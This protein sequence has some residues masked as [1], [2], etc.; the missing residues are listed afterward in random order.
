MLY[1]IRLVF[2]RRNNGKKDNIKEISKRKYGRKIQKEDFKKTDMI[3]LQN[4]VRSKF[5][6]NKNMIKE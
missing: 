2:V 6:K 1:Y 5:Q 4:M 3:H